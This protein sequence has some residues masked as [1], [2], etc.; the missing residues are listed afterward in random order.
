MHPEHAEHHA[1]H[2]TIRLDHRMMKDVTIVV[3]VS[4]PAGLRLRASLW[5]MKIAGRLG[6]FR[7]VRLEREK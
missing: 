2:L 6:G 4:K 1:S 5:L 7:S 3:R